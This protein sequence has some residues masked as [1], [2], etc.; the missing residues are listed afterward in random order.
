MKVEGVD[1]GEVDENIFVAVVVD[2]WTMSFGQ[3]RRH[4]LIML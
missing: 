1:G 2:R 3:R 4:G